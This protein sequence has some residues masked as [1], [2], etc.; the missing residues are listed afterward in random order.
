[1]HIFHRL[2]KLG[3]ETMH[4]PLELLL[5]PKK[6]NG[7]NYQPIHFPIGGLKPRIISLLLLWFGVNYM[8]IYRN[9][10]ETKTLEV[11]KGHY[12]AKT[13]PKEKKEDT[14]RY[15]IYIADA[16]FNQRQVLILHTTSFFQHAIFSA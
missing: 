13:K 9:H 16:N 12:N 1:M 15:K 3:I 6:G 2:Q 4:V 5:I 14:K 10:Y 11:Q 7:E 8:S